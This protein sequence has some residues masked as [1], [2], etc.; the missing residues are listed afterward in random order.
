LL[1]ELL[2]QADIMIVGVP[3]ESFPGERRVALVPELVPKLTAAGLE[4]YVQM[5][6]GVEAGFGDHDYEEKGACLA[7]DVFAK[8]DVI[9]KV[10]PPTADEIQKMREASVFIG[11]LDPFTSEAQIRLL[12]ARNVTSFAMEL[13][14]RIARAQ[15]MDALSAMSTVAGYKAVLLAAN[16]L[17]KFFPLLMTAAGTITPARV[18]VVGA[19]VAGL[20]A[21]GT[22]K[23]LGAVVE[24]YDTRSAVK[25]EAQSVGARFVE[26]TLDTK[27]AEE[28]GGYARAESP[29]FYKKQQAMM[30]EHVA[31]A[32]V[33]IT[34]A[35]VRGR[36]A[37]VLLTETLVRTM[38]PGSVIVDLA[39]AQGGNCAL[40][41]ADKEVVR[42]GVV[43]LGPTNLPSTMPIHSSQLYART[44]TNF[45][46]H[47]FP[48]GRIRFDPNDE[49]T[50]ATLVTHQGEMVNDAL[51]AALTVRPSFS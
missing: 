5:G 9:L 21:I 27:E 32:D 26:L 23:R 40:T 41:E 33:V 13:M 8:A 22:A 10:R 44:V 39:A 17:P 36:H 35:L 1:N 50:Y 29:E 43:I 30:L 24:A 37:P 6:A 51:R 25:E 20:E 34:A 42:Y 4:V 46:L 3:A 19:G 12:G 38:R 31:A 49:L 47:L 28:K 48:D 18:F 11:L 2:L 16:R 7:P 45:L 14:P 15:P